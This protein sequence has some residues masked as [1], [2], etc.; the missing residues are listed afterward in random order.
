MELLLKKKKESLRIPEGNVYV[1][2]KDVDI[3]FIIELKEIHP[4]ASP[5][6]VQNLLPR[7]LRGQYFDGPRLLVL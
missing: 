1:Y 7:S 3:C 6:V 2:R 4:Q 5:V